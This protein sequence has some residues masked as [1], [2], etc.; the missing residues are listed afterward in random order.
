MKQRFLV[1][2]RAFFAGIGGFKSGNRNQLELL[3]NPNFKQGVEK[4]DRVT[5][6]FKYTKEPAQTMIDRCLASGNPLQVGKF[7]VPDV[8][9]AIGLQVQDIERLAP[10]IERLPDKHEWQEVVY[11][12]YLANGTF[13]LTEE[14]RQEAYAAY[15]EARSKEDKQQVE[16]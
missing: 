3:D 16:E 13:T 15:K 2:S 4:N 14:Q 7:L 8:A 10:L 5:R 11:N 1:G 12:A 9:H 6:V